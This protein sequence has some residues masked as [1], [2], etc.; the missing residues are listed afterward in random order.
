MVVVVSHTVCVRRACFC[1]VA[2]AQ[3][4]GEFQNE[5]SY[6]PSDLA[7]FST[8]VGETIAKPTIV[9]PFQ[10]G[11]DPESSLDIMVGH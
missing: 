4:V 8:S 9:G 6:T 10:A 1:C 2:V 3:G 11:G 5:P 7:T